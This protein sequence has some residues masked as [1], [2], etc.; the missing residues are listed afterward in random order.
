MH[1]CP[2]EIV[3][4]M[5]E[6]LDGEISSEH[7]RVLTEH[8]QTCPDCQRHMD[9]LN[10]V[11]YLVGT[12]QAMPVPAGFTERVMFRLPKPKLKSGVQRWLRRHPILVAAALFMILMSA[13]LLSGYNDRSAFSVTEHPG[14]IVEGDR[15]TVPAGQTVK[16][17]IVVTNGDLVID[18]K[19]EGDVTVINGKYMASTANVTGQI[20]EIDDTFEWLWYTIKDGTKKLFTFE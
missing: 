14:M 19:V 10:R 3:H 18:G 5:H 17:D 15:V 8:L 20:E 4:Y 9:E 2:K 11:V 7:D 12:L 13:S 1:T 16:G 6:R